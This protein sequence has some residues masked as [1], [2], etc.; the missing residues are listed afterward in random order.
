MILEGYVRDKHGQPIANA[1]LEIKGEDFLTI[2]SAE[3]DE[4]GYYRF[5]IPQGNYPFLIAVKDYAV[6]NLEYWCQNIPLQND[7][8]LDIS[9]DKLEIYGLHVF[10]VK[11][12]GKKLMVYFRPM[13]LLKY[14]QGK[15]DIAPQNISVKVTVD[16]EECAV[17]A[18]NPVKEYADGHAMSAYLLQVDADTHWKKF[19]IEITD[20]DGC[21]GAATIFN[22]DN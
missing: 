18:E 15:S 9:F 19:D 3:S 20:E 2:Y 10:T 21:Y 16:G 14:Q 5:D 1:A 13:S 7:M 8:R 22:T 11:G 4:H 12:A 17:I 6:H